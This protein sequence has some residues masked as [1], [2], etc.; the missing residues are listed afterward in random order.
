MPKTTQLT[1]SLASKPGVLAQVASALS[2]AGVN[3]TGLCAAEA[4]G[5][6]GKLRLLVDNPARATEALRAAKLRVGQEEALTLTLENRPG[7]LA[8]VAQKLG[9]ARVNIKCAYATTSG[10]GP[11]LVVLSVSNVAKAEAALGR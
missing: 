2:Q 11:A 3:I 1:L 5:G 4:A 9:R 8:D 10:P 6:R 7:A